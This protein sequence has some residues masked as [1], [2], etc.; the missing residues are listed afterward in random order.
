MAKTKAEKEHGA[1]KY[2]PAKTKAKKNESKKSKEA[3]KK[4]EEE[5]EEELRDLMDRIPDPRGLE[6]L[7][8]FKDED[9]P[10]FPRERGEW[11]PPVD[12]LHKDDKEKGVYRDHK[13]DI[14]RIDLA[15]GGTIKKNYAK[16]GGV[17]KA[18]FTDS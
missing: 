9:T 14:D 18:K 17:R 4:K 13:G 7:E 2:S 5:L 10:V 8:E 16:G 6:E 1:G 3:T 15:S 11:K 12:P